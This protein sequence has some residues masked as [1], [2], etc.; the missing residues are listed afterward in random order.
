M[1]GSIDRI[2]GKVRPAR[3]CVLTGERLLPTRERSGPT[4]ASFVAIGAIEEA[5]YETIVTIGATP[6]AIN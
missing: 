3:N 1:C 5:M 2:E 4:V 6:G